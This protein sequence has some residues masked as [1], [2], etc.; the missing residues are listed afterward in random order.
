MTRED[1]LKSRSYVTAGIQLNLL[2]MMEDYMKENKLS[3]KELS[4]KLKV[5]KGYISQILNVNYDHKISKVV[6]LALS[7]NKMPI[8]SFV[9]LDR[10]IYEDANDKYFELIPVQRPKS[11]RYEKERP[12]ILDM[13]TKSLT[14]EKKSQFT[15]YYNSQGS[16]SMPLNLP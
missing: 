8:V 10:F 13:E 16:F 3:R 6:D 9:D 14:A 15:A 2:N 1:L 11:I 4:D 5:S 12:F 7:L